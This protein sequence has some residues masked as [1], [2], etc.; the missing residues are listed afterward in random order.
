MIKF[1][2][3]SQPVSMKNSRQIVQMG[4]R[5]ASIKSADA[6]EYERTTLLQIPPEHRKS[7]EGPFR[8]TVHAYSE[9][10]RPDLDL[11]LLMDCLQNRYKKVKGALV[12]VSDGVYKH[13]DSERVLTQKGV[14]ANDRQFREQHF[15]HHI[16]KDRP[17]AEIEIEPILG[18]LFE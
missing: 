4:G 3:L 12:K 13:A 14:V 10:E 11:A 2:I 1:T 9:S 8:I 17:R 7:L 16:D 18:A 5:P 6:R 15:F